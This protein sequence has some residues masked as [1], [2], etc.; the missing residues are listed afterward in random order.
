MLQSMLR[1]AGMLNARRSAYAVIRNLS[2]T[3]DFN[4]SVDVHKHSISL[5]Q[6]RAEKLKEMTPATTGSLIPDS[7]KH[8]EED[9]EHITT[10]ENLK[11]LG[12]AALTREERVRRRRALDQFGLPTFA[13]FLNKQ[14][15]EKLSKKPISILQMNIGLYCNQACNHCHVESSP[16]RKE[17]MSEAIAKRCMELME[18]TPSITTVDIT[19]GAPELN[20]QF[21]YLVKEGRRQGKEVIDRCNLTV[22]SEPGQEGLAQFLADNQYNLYYWNYL[23]STDVEC[24]ASSPTQLSGTDTALGLRSRYYLS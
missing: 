9:E 11:K 12:Q 19:G 16:K 18:R 6:T 14:K 8:V 20:D 7:I 21:K 2:T 1:P 23:L 17:M 10:A 3:P 13:D 5:R 22:L 24:R 4:T 15:L